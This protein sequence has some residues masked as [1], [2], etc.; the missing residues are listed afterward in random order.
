[1]DN[2]SKPNSQVRLLTLNQKGRSLSELMTIAAQ[3]RQDILSG[4]KGTTKETFFAPNQVLDM[5]IGLAF[6]R[7][8]LFKMLFN[9][10]FLKEGDTLPQSS[11][12][13][14]FFKSIDNTLK[15]DIIGHIAYE[16]ENN[17]NSVFRE[18]IDIISSNI[19]NVESEESLK[20]KILPI[21]KNKPY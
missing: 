14:D 5:L 20:E 2:Y 3:V 17:P 12:L 11:L 15:Q 10:G 8:D 13:S 4:K 19:E 1:L 21:I 6:K 16:K 18:V 9:Q 7:P